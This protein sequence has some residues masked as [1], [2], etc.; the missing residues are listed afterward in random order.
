MAVCSGE[1]GENLLGCGFGYSTW[2]LTNF[3]LP[4]QAITMKNVALIAWQ[5]STRLVQLIEPEN[6]P[7]TLLRGCT[8][9]TYLKARHTQGCETGCVCVCVCVFVNTVLE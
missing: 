9:E 5:A 2:A 8:T 7:Q 1:V 6:L 4:L 3:K